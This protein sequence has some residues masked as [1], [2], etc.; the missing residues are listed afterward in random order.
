MLEDMSDLPSPEPDK[1]REEASMWLA[2]LSRGLRAEEVP[3]LRQWLRDPINRRTILDMSRL[4]HG[5]EITAVLAE[6]FPPGPEP[7]Q[8]DWWRNFLR[9]ALA[10]AL[11]IALLSLIITDR[12]PWSDLQAQWVR[13]H[14]SCDSPASIIRAGGIYS[15]AVGQKSEI[16]LHDGSTVTLN[17]HSCMSVFYTQG[18]REVYLPY[19][20]ANFHV[21]HDTKR[22][23]F[24]RAGGLGRNSGRRFQAVGTNFD[25]RVLTTDN[26][27]IT[28]TEGN[29]KVM[30]APAAD[31]DTPAAAR[32]RDN[33][34]YDDTTVGALETA[35]VEPGMQFV[36]KLDTSDIDTL[37]AWRQGMIFFKSAPLE[38]A[39]AEM[40]RYTTT[41]FVVADEKLRDVRIGGQFRTGDV[42]GLLRTLRKDFLIDSRRDPQGRVVLTAL[43]GSSMKSS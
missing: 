38:A 19:G 10:L 27:A 20:E 39:L 6:L 7:V 14:S 29:V 32:L 34:I 28:V 43:S 40:D 21:A 1:A 15:T 5:P 24:V 18:V 13:L 35:L 3:G 11:T 17:T 4:W 16:S 37:L 36:R 22:P 30:Y 9:G 31:D 23:F 42:D 25:V 2:K 33:M 12:H 41:Q 26:V 8:W